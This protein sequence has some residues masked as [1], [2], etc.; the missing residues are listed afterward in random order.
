MKYFLTIVTAI[1]VSLTAAAQE[2]SDIQEAPDC[3]AEFSLDEISGITPSVQGETPQGMAISNGV[4]FAL[5]HGGRCITIDLE[6]RQLL[7]EFAIEGAEGTHCNN[8]SFGVGSSDASRFPLLYVSECN[9]PSRCFVEEVTERGSHLVAT[10]IYEGSGI[11][12]FCDWCVDRENGHL[13][14]YGR[15]PEKGVVLKC[16]K[17]PDTDAANESGIITLGDKDLLKEFV[18]PAGFFGIAQGSHISDG[19]IYLPTGHPRIG[20]C[21]IN[22]VSL[23]TGE[24]TARYDITGIGLEPEGVCTFGNRLWQFFGGGRGSIYSFGI[25]SYN[26]KL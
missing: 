17:I 19:C 14:A 15:T 3:R 26:K 7:A 12:S 8:A 11:D 13:Y 20:S 4:L 6:T 18:Y 1:T 5:Y 9:A 25:G 2:V 23:D 21:H 10:I 22:V 24:R 16:F